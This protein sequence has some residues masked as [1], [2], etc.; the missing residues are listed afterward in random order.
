MIR[1][2]KGSL[3]IALIC[4]FVGV[5]I[6][7]QMKTVDQIGGSVDSERAGDLAAELKVLE[8]KNQE[9]TDQLKDLQEQLAVYE[10]STVG[11]DEAI[12]KK[13]EALEK[14]KI[15]AGVVDTVGEGLVI[16]IDSEIS[17]SSDAALYSKSSDL[18]LALVN[19]LN[20]AGA[21]A[22][23]INDER[24]INT[25]EIRQAGS[26]I[27][28][29]RNKYAAPFEVKVIGNPQDLSAAI[30]MRAGVVDTMQSNKLKVTI[31]EEDEVFIAAYDGV[32]TQK[33]ARPAADNA[34]EE[35]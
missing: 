10:T 18:L 25:S 26:Y 35:E 13:K 2:R 33:Y 9:L 31:Q 19:E 20:A 17:Q 34:A 30:K 4:I 5:L 6:I 12:Q 3:A 1:K 14:E 11:S 23:A 32:V 21:E 29:N 16:T 28:I 15:L 8:D 7:L 22:I 24:I 27:N